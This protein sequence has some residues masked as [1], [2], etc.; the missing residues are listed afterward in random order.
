MLPTSCVHLFCCGSLV[1]YVHSR[2]TG[3]ILIHS[4]CMP[5]CKCGLIGQLSA[6]L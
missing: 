5:Q 1:A 3:G 4:R 2:V 6:F